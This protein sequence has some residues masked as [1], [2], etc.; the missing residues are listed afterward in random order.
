RG[1][2]RPPAPNGPAATETANVNAGQER[3][4]HKGKAAAHEEATSSAA[5][6]N[7]NVNATKESGKRKGKRAEAATSPAATENAN[8]NAT[9]QEGGKGKGK[10]SE[11]AM[12]QASPSPAAAA[13][14]S[15]A[16]S[17]GAG[18]KPTKA[19]NIGKNGKQV[20]VQ[21]IKGQ[22]TNFRAQA[23]PQQINT[24]THNQDYS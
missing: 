16:A 19:G 2:T 20:D 23:K 7:A 5:T 8:V 14:T 24:V 10:R 13:G 12:K 11:A 18:A 15:A 22:H 21:R 3:G 6:E 4:K 17:G 1:G 9:T